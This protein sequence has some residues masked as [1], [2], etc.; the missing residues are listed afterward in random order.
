[1]EN[2]VKI[3]N[4]VVNLEAIAVAEK[5]PDGSL[6]IHCIGGRKAKFTAAQADGLWGILQRL[7]RTP[8]AFMANAP[9]GM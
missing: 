5:Q 7:S 1:M 2:L 6:T 3:E 8:S 9:I 4:R